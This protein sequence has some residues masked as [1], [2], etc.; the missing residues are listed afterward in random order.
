MRPP[1]L[2]DVLAA[3]LQEAGAVALDRFLQVEA[4]RKG[5]L[6]EVTEADRLA[7]AVLVR[8]LG[9]SFPGEGVVGE[10]G[11]RIDGERTWY[12]DPIDG[13]ACYLEGLTYWGPVL[14][15]VVDGAPEAGGVLFPRLGELWFGQRGAGAWR[16]GRRLPQL[17]DLRLGRSSVVLMPSRF[18]T[19][20]TLD[21]P[22]KVRNLGS[23][24]AHLCQVAAGG[25]VATLV[26]PGWRPWDVVAGLVLL[27]EVGGVALSLDGSPLHV[28]SDPSAPF[29]AGSRTACDDL[30][31]TLRP[32]RLKRA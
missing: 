24:A 2:H 26:G 7:E 8:G 19:V 29:V 15:R 3:L 13:T 14:G 28:L 10:E 32:H 12:V 23:I 21:V 11:A 16:S 27:E 5:D 18:H 25:A 17:G 6:T 1:P 4:E 9:E 20:A 22:C 31:S 30:L